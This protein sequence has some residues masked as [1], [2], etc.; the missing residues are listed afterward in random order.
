[1]EHDQMPVSANLR[2]WKFL[3]V[4]AISSLTGGVRET[5]TANQDLLE[6]PHL[7]RGQR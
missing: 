7:F 2:S 4:F 1:M 3:G 5:F 6:S